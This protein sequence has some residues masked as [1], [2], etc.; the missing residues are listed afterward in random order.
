MFNI[1][2]PKTVDLTDSTET[3]IRYKDVFIS[4]TEDK[5]GEI[6]SIGWMRGLQ[7]HTPVREYWTA[8]PPNKELTGDK[9]G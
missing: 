3:V 7:T 2:K 8:I 6:T 5:Y 9:D 1:F 4:V